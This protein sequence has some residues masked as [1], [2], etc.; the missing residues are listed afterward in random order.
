MLRL[1]VAARAEGLKRKANAQ[2][3]QDID[4]C[5]RSPHG[6][7]HSPTD[8][9]ALFKVLMRGAPGPARPAGV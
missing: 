1:G 7:E 9:G 4:S 8:M 5:P 2:Q 6:V 3:A